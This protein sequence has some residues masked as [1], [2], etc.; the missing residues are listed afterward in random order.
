MTE[1]D[2][3]VLADQESVD[4]HWTMYIKSTLM[5]LLTVRKVHGIVTTAQ[6]W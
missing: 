2:A 4:K 3:Q 5:V 1:I 6:L